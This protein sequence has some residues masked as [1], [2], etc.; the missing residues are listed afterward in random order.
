MISL[1][2]K[3]RLIQ[4]WA[5]APV[6]GA[7]GPTTADAIMA[8]AGIARPPSFDRIEF[9]N[10]Y[11]NR[12]APAIDDIDRKAAAIVLK[13]SIKHIHAIEK[14]ESNG[15]S[16]DNSG[17]PI[18]LPE[19]HIFYRL[20]GGKFGRTPFSY[21][22]W[23]ERPYPGSYDARWTMLADMASCDEGAALQSASWGLF[24]VMGF[25]YAACGF[26]TP[27]DYAAA[28]AADEGDHLEA[29]VR[30]IQSEGLDDEL[31]ACKAGDA[32]SCVP[33][34]SRYNGSGYKKNNYHV[35]FAEALL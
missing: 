33:F 7:Y 18:I 23:G 22:K 16:F 6:D 17:R 32:A 35:K 12:A 24:Q 34:V 11:V 1:I 5:G 4:Q 31:R 2:D 20:T 29:M 13:V 9:L 30:F 15:V 27:Q 25:H 28:M 10:R 21:P 3:T 14:V 26:D 19:P 8:K